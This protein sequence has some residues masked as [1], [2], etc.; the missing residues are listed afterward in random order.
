MTF[1][2]LIRNCVCT[3]AGVVMI[4]DINECSTGTYK[5]SADAVCVNTKGSY[6]DLSV[7][8]IQDFKE[9]EVFAKVL[10]TY[11]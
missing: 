8:V 2:I 4:L 9:T 1:L 10:E 7:R 11:N 3:T 5:C 6:T